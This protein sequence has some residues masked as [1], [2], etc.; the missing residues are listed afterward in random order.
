MKTV[1]ERNGTRQFKQLSR[2]CNLDYTIV[3]RRSLHAPYAD[4]ADSKDGT[5]NLT[6][7]Y[8]N[9]NI[10][11]VNR[12]QKLE[13]PIMLQDLTV[14]SRKDTKEGTNYYLEED[15]KNNK[16]RLWAEV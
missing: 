16:V 2:W 11:P 14:I 9:H 10:T 5:L 13:V 1:K 8:I 7:F 12:F 15:K 6:Y 3:T 4:N